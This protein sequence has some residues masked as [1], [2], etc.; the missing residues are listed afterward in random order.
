ML[1]PEKHKKPNWD[2]W[3]NFSSSRCE[4]FR[5]VLHKTEFIVTISLLFM[6]AT[7]NPRT[8]SD[9]HFQMKSSFLPN[10]HP[11]DRERRRAMILYAALGRVN[12]EI[13][14]TSHNFHPGKREK[15]SLTSV[16]MVPLW[17][18][19][20]LCLM[21]FGRYASNYINKNRVNWPWRLRNKSFLRQAFSPQRR[22]ISIDMAV[23]YSKEVMNQIRVMVRHE[24][25]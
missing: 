15:H 4:R 1:L 11:E 20:Y 25:R 8:I 24:K 2:S 13:W 19:H 17:E 23:R 12:H 16:K 18:Y 10:Y 9:D 7:H 14:T 3:K 22:S 6:P 21:G 5:E